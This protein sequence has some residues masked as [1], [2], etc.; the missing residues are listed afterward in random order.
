MSNK[1]QETEYLTKAVMKRAVSKGIKQASEKAMETAGSLIEVDGDWIVR[2][3]K[4]GRTE[5]LQELPKV[6]AKEMEQ[7]INRLTRG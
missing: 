4:D 1:P 5:K 6:S 3:Y 2:R 7:K